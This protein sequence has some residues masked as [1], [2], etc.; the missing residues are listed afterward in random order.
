MKI[1]AVY[2]KQ[3]EG[4]QGSDRI[5][6][7]PDS[8]LVNTGKPV[9][10]PDS[11]RYLI[12]G[13]GVKIDA[14]GKSISPRFAK[15]YYNDFFPMVFFLRED[16][17]AQ[18]M[19]TEDPY[20]KDLVEDYSIIQGKIWESME[21]PESSVLNITFTSLK[22][23]EVSAETVIA[24]DIEGTIHH[25]IS[26]ASKRNTLKTGDIVACFLKLSVKAN[27]EHLLKIT[28]E[29]GETLIENKLK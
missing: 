29:D 12:L 24:N 6:V 2:G 20:A 21:N 7:W 22:S 5:L 14:V 4:P 10:L 25:A 15:R 11:P 13:I 17:A 26:V 9:F 8:V 1:V 19:K 23:S 27:P 18:I 28:S 3:P 16:V